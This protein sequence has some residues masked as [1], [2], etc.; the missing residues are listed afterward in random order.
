MTVT[1]ERTE[2]TTPPD[3]PRRRRALAAA[4]VIALA[5]GGVLALAERQRETAPSA[6][7]ALVD[8]AATTKVVGDVSNALIKIFSYTPGDLAASEKAAAEVLSGKAAQQYRTLFAEVRRQ[9][10]AQ[11]LTLT[12]RVV[13]AGVH[14]LDGGTAHLLVFLDQVSTRN[15]KPAGGTSAAQLAVTAHLTGGQWRIV[16]IRSS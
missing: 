16:D 14:R 1:E 12:T 8:T 3:R 2:T 11:K 10:P 15:G 5:A 4:L 13:R 7:R 9:A 6:N